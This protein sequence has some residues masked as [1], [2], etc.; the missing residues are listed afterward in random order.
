MSQNIVQEILWDYLVPKPRSKYGFVRGEMP[1]VNL[2]LAP[3][4]MGMS[5][6]FFPLYSTLIPVRK[7]WAG[8]WL[9][10][11]TGEPSREK[12]EY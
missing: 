2:M 11:G 10:L 1:A 7:K 4:I 12:L 9:L 8:F 3:G 5:D 6:P